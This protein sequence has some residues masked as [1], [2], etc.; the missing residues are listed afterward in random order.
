MIVEHP[1]NGEGATLDELF[2]RA[3]VQA[4]DALALIDPPNKQ[5]FAGSAPRALTFA[6]ADRLI[7]AVAARL[8]GLGLQTD[9]IVALQLPNTLECVIALLGILRAGMIAAPLPLLW[10]QQDIVAALRG[11]G[12]KA[13]VTHGA[14]LAL[15]ATLA[16][17]DLFSI[18]HVCAFGGGL[19]DGVVPLD[20]LLAGDEPDGMHAA[21][22]PGPAAAHVA[23]I[24]FEVAAGGPV[25][26]ARSHL[27]LMAGGLSIFREARLAPQAPVLSAIPP[28]SFAGV[29]LTIMPWLLAGGSLALHHGGDPAVLAA[30]CQGLAGGALV[31]PGP[32][33]APLADGGA[34][35]AGIKTIAA[36]WRSPERLATAAVWRGAPALVDVASFGEIGFVAKGAAATVCRRRYRLALSISRASR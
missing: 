31:L 32:A 9:A 1:H 35:G 16:A 14:A 8:R 36:L 18:R 29:A 23:L 3:G 15:G 21:P 13:I 24:S 28:A 4:P 34:L 33:L 30:Q 20:E 22:R 27:Q 10:R 5:S 12:A 7:S 19:P 11:I 26:Y 6:Q 25:A 17:V 2:R